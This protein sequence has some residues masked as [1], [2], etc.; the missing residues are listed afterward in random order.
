M[1]IS[2]PIT[3]SVSHPNGGRDF[4]AGDI[5]LLL[6]HNEIEIEFRGWV[7]ELSGTPMQ[8]NPLAER[9]VVSF[10]LPLG[11]ATQQ[12]ST[13]NMRNTTERRKWGVPAL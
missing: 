13:G 4:C 10:V 6:G 3:G 9:S 7:A 11:T 12:H 8:V 2:V 1:T 5:G